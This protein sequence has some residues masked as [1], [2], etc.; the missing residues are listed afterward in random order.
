MEVER[1][2]AVVYRHLSSLGR[3]LGITKTLR[4]REEL[5][6]FIYQVQDI[7]ALEEGFKVPRIRLKFLELVQ[8]RFK[9][10]AQL[11]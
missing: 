9:G 7:D 3:I 10:I 6:L 11:V 1:F 5:D 2:A 4:H 8:A